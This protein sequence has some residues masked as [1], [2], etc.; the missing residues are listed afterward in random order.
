MI[1]NYKKLFIPAREMR[2]SQTPSE[3][4]IWNILKNRQVNDLKFLRQKILGEFIVDFY[5][6]E[7]KLVIEIDGEIHDTQKERD[8]ERDFYLK[9]KFN[10]KIIRYKN[11]FILKNEI[12]KIKA[13]LLK[14]IEP[15]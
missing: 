7:I 4:K 2:K 8:N 5:C 13:K 6:N 11:N 3:K 15:L 14:D 9:E 10:L 12:E 1:Y